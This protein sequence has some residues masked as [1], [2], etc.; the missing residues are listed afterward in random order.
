VCLEF[1]SCIVFLCLLT[2]I[3]VL[4]SEYPHCGHAE[5]P[6]PQGMHLSTQT[7]TQFQ[8]ESYP[9]TGTVADSPLDAVLLVFAVSPGLADLGRPPLVSIR[10][11]NSIPCEHHLGVPAS[12][13]L[14][15]PYSLKTASR[16]P[17]LCVCFEQSNSKFTPIGSIHI[18]E[19]DMST[20]RCFVVYRPWS[21]M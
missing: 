9:H 13:I 20:I 10:N 19:A 12:D 6:R 7:H 8:V 21:G 15:F 5:Q 4:R 16:S 3:C 14:S 1:D 11:L 17:A 2:S 18:H